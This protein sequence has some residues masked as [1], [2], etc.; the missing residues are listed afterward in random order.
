ML[1]RKLR[2]FVVDENGA[3]AIEYALIAGI[4]SIAIVSGLRAVTGTLNTGLHSAAT[5]LENAN[6]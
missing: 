2:T 6:D 5:G 3:T 4:V 1:R